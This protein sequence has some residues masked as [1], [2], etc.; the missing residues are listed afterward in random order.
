MRSRRLVVEP[1]ASDHLA[2]VVEAG[3]GLSHGAVTGTAEDGPLAIVHSGWQR[4][5]SGGGIR[6]HQPPTFFQLPL[7]HS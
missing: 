3:L 4:G 7:S 6:S 2:Q 1:R 5:Q